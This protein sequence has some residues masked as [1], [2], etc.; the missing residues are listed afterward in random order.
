MEDFGH[1]VQDCRPV[2]PAADCGRRAGADQSVVRLKPCPQPPDET[3]EVRPL[4]AVEGVQLV[5]H[6]KAQHAADVVP[7]EW[8]VDRPREQ[9]IEHLVVGEQDVRRVFAQDLAVLDEVVRSHSPTGRRTGLTHVQPRRH[10]APKRRSAVDDRGNAPRLIR[11]ESVHGIDDDGLDA[12]RAGLRAAVIEHRVEEALRLAGTGS[13]R[14]DGGLATGQPIEGGAL[15]A[16]G[17]E[18]E[19][20]FRKRLAAFRCALK[21][22]VDGE[23]R[24]LEQVIGVSEKVRHHIG[25]CRIRRA[26]AGREEVPQG[27]GDFGGEGGGDHGCLRRSSRSEVEVSNQPASS[28]ASALSPIA[29]TP[30]PLG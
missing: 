5:H 27:A 8:K 23:V 18:A 22:Q 3:G 21:R 29:S 12:G 6:Q 10:P 17:G 11:R 7:P 30:P 28:S 2:F 26:E 16:I 20:G 25:Q 14:D 15:M 9:Q 4:R 24:P 13:G 19:R 1:V